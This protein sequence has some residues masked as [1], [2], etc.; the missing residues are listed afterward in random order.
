MHQ[1]GTSSLLKISQFEG[2]RNGVVHSARLLI[3]SLIVSKRVSLIME[4]YDIKNPHRILKIINYSNF[5]FRFHFYKMGV[6]IR[7]VFRPRQTRQLPRAVDLKGRLLS[8]QSY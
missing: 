4:G 7:G 6:Q 1:V 8:S 2:S 5:S 3:D